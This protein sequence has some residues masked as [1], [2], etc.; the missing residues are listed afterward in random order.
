MSLV[1]ENLDEK[2]FFKEAEGSF[3]LAPGE[4]KYI[5]MKGRSASVQVTVTGTSYYMVA[6]TQANTSKVKEGSSTF[7]DA[8]AVDFSESGDYVIETGG[9]IKIENRIDS[10]DDIEVDWRV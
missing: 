7:I 3:S 10:T 6:A 9:G 5:L 4:V 1:I 8:D 2:G